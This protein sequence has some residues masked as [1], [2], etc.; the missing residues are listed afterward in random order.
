VSLPLARD[1]RRAGQNPGPGWGAKSLQVLG[2]YCHVPKTQ[3][4]FTLEL[5]KVRLL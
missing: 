2:I 4:D 3:L 5:R 1:S